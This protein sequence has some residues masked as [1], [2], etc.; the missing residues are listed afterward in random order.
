MVKKAYEYVGLKE[1]KGNDHNLEILKMFNDIG[2][3]WVKDDETAWCSCFVNYLAQKIG[4]ERSGK[5]T[6]RSWLKVG[7][8]IISPIPGDIVVFW[9]ESRNSWKGHV[10]IYIG[11][12]RKGDILCLGGNQNNE[13]NIS[14][15]S[16]NKVLEFRRVG[17][18]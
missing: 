6:A 10:G 13:V 17:G 7:T 3:E 15:Y 18:V 9:R 1:I 12:D 8:S 5:L 11:H 2:C 14:T 16:K 4:V